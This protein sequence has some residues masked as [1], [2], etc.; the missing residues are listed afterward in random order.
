MPLYVTTKRG[1]RSS[2]MTI[3]NRHS[4]CVLRGARTEQDDLGLCVLAARWWANEHVQ[5][6]SW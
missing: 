5:T 1:Q 6:K 3:S 4:Q 2:A